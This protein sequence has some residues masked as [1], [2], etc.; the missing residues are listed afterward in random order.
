MT[1]APSAEEVLAALEKTP[2]LVAVVRGPTYLYEFV[3]ERYAAVVGFEDPIG[4]PF[5]DS[6]HPAVTA[7]RE[8][9]DRV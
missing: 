5:G 1:A 9:L 2:A 6:R 8:A 3:N 7:L 4:K